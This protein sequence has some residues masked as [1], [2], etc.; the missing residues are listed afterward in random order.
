MVAVGVG[1]RV[2]SGELEII[3]GDPSRVF[4]V[5]T[6]NNLDTIVGSLT[7]TIGNTASLVMVGESV[8]SK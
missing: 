7:Q 3:A 5:S 4:S 8:I 6:Y 2:D 1:S